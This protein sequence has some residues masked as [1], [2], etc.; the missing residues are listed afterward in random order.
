M[1]DVLLANK[2]EVSKRKK[3]LQEEFDIVMT[4]TLDREVSGMCNLSEG[5]FERG[6]NEG[7]NEATLKTKL[8]AIR[9][10][11]GKLKLSAEESMDILEI[12]ETEREWY[13]E[14]LKEEA[15]LQV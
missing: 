1:L 10:L 14:A 3:I 6:W 2:E 12:P 11:M 9:N 5:V 4:E 8:E 7:R 15:A 13:G